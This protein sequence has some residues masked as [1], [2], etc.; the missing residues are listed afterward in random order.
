[1]F[2]F[3]AHQM[4]HIVDDA[5]RFDCTLG[6]LSAYEFENFLRIIAEVCDLSFF[7]LP[8]LWTAPV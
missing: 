2:T 7:N 4:L 3:L 8:E 6:H 5:E 1:M